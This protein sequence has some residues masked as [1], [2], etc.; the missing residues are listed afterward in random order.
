MADDCLFCKIING[1]IP[2]VTLYENNS[3]IAFMDIMPVAPGHCLIVPKQHFRNLLD[4]NAEAIA[5]VGAASI[6]IANAVKQALAADGIRVMQF[7]EAAAGQTVFHYHLHIIPVQAGQ[8]FTTHGRNKVD[9]SEL[10]AVADKII[11]CL[12][13]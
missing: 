9:V 7:N 2:A 12:A 11:H 4:A 6:P 3:V 8:G 5:A 1:D 13:A 10:Q